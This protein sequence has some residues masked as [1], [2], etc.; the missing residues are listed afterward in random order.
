MLFWN[1]KIGRHITDFQQNLPRLSA[2]TR[3]L[4]LGLGRKNPQRRNRLKCVPGV[5]KSEVGERMWTQRMLPCFR[6]T[7]FRMNTDVKLGSPKG[8]QGKTEMSKS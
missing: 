3:A 5:W 4:G 1:L 6:V 2:K 7:L 8:F